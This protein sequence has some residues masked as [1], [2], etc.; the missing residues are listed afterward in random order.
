[1]SGEMHLVNLPI[2][3]FSPHFCHF[4]S[5]VSKLSVQHPVGRHNLYSCFTTTVH[6]PQPHKIGGNFSLCILILKFFNRRSKNEI[7][8]SEVQH[9]FCEFNQKLA[10]SQMQYDLLTFHFK[11]QLIDIQ[12]IRLIKTWGLS[13]LLKLFVVRKKKRII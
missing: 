4:F 2:I 11:L 9:A 6:F 10:S 13:I 12:F 1:M 5:E 8:R 3:Q 7:F